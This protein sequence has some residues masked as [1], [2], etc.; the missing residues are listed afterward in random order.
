MQ[1]L[2]SIL[3]VVLFVGAT[4]SAAPVQARAKLHGS[5]A[6]T[7]V[8]SCTV[9]NNSPTPTPFGIDPSGAPTLIPAGGVFRL[10][11]TDSS[12]ETF[13]GMVPASPSAE[14]SR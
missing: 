6:V 13:N 2:T 3:L 9:T 8:R 7:S 12:I 11:S 1:R 4:G 14:A 5:Y 10:H